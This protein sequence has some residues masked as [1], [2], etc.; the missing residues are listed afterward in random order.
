[1]SLHYPHSGHHSLF[2]STTNWV[3]TPYSMAFRTSL[4]V[5]PSSLSA[6]SRPAAISSNAKPSS[7][8]HFHND[9]A[10]TV[11]VGEDLPLQYD[12]WLPKQDPKSR[13][14]AG[15]LLHPS[16]FPGPYGIG[17][18]G[19]QAFRFLDWLHDTGCS[20]WQVIEITDFLPSFFGRFVNLLSYL[21]KSWTKKVH[22]LFFSNDLV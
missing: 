8:F 13:R 19:P 16:S 18:L 3:C 12:T 21:C 20:L 11:S 6:P 9:G 22:Y 1:M 4:S 14:R 15:I 5:V 10:L 17:D 7:Q 2:S